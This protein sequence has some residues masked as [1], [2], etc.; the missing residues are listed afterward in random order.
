MH[1]YFHLR[2]MLEFNTVDGFVS[3][4]KNEREQAPIN[5][6]GIGNSHPVTDR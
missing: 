5:S 6:Q 4:K 2:H 1:F 3:A